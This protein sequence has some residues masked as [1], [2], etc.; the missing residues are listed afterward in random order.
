LGSAAQID[1]LILVGV[2]VQELDECEDVLV[3]LGFQVLDF[4]TAIL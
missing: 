1:R 4:A 2:L 3:D